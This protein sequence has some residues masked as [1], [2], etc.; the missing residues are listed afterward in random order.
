MSE[1]FEEFKTDQ[2]N[3][4]LVELSLWKL[5]EGLT[6]DLVL[7]AIPTEPFK[8][9][10]EMLAAEDHEDCEGSAAVGSENLDFLGA[11]RKTTE[12]IFE[13]RPDILLTDL[14]CQIVVECVTPSNAPIYRETLTPMEII[15]VPK[16]EIRRDPS[17]SGSM[18]TYYNVFTD[19]AL[20][21]GDHIRYTD[22]FQGQLIDIYVKDVSGGI[23]IEDNT[24]SFRILY[25]A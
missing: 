25:C 21:I 13:T 8:I 17:G 12:V 2:N 15:C 6:S 14:D 22:P 3:A 23:D 9:A 19:V 16:T 1:Y 7:G 11:T 10:V 24:E 20:K 18:T 4:W 5:Y